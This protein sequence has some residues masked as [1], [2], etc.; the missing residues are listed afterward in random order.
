M[1]KKELQEY[2]EYYTPGKECTCGIKSS[3][4]CE[5]N[6]DWTDPRVYELMLDKKNLIEALGK[7]LTFGKISKEHSDALIVYKRFT[8]RK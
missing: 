4:S 5:C 1:N 2:L 8:Q 6:A 3:D 7:A